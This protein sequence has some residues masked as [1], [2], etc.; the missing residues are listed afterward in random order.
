[1][2]SSAL[3]AWQSG[4]RAAELNRLIETHQSITGGGP[5]RK[6]ETEHMNFALITRVV[7]EFQGY[8]R[9]LHNLGVNAIVDHMGIAAASR[10]T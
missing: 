6:W 10:P 3:L 4:H 2:T 9:D 8:C 1:M 7:A 5:G